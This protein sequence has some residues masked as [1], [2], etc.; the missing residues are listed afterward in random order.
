SI[1]QGNDA[2]LL[3]FSRATLEDPKNPV[4]SSMNAA[5][6]EGYQSQAKALLISLGE[7]IHK[8]QADVGDLDLLELK[9][10]C[11]RAFA[12]PGRWHGGFDQ[13]V[14]KRAIERHAQD[15]KTLKMLADMG[16]G[17]AAL[18]AIFGT[19]G[20]ALAFG[21]VGVGLGVARAAVDITE[22]GRLETAAKA[23]P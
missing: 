5:Q 22:A 4:G 10:L 7:R 3:N 17:A 23:T 9:P 2:A 1:A 20:L 16:E 11:E 8:A 15:V 13:W 18:V 6:G 19:G 21:A 14:A 12:A